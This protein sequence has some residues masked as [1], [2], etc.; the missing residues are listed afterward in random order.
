M[1][2]SHQHVAPCAKGVK[3]RLGARGLI[4]VPAVWSG[5]L[6]EVIQEAGVVSRYRHAAI[7]TPFSSPHTTRRETVGIYYPLLS[8]GWKLNTSPTGD[9]D[10]IGNIKVMN[11]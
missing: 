4:T 3:W 11:R 1:Q 7:A 2:P 9:G 6:V 5:I 10:I 8:G